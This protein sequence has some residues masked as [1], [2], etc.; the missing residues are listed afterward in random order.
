MKQIFAPLPLRIPVDNFKTNETWTMYSV[1]EQFS[2]SESDLERIATICNE[3]LVYQ[4]LFEEKLNGI[5]YSL[6]NA[7]GFID[8]A[9][10]G[11][12]DQTYFVFLIR[13]TDGIIQAAVDIKSNNL[14]ASEV[15]YWASG[16]KPGIV[17]NAVIS[18]CSIAQEKGFVSL[19]ADV[20]VA[21]DR[22]KKVLQRAGYKE[23][24]KLIKE[25][26][27]YVRFTKIL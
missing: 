21:N 17:T 14:E 3:P 12:R 10:N 4:W 24:E 9:R 27:D 25:G 22:S 8:W 23:S 1:D 19:Y 16:D 7:R 26:K 15:G 6:E 20:Q 18:L 11:W 5:A 2:V 13:D